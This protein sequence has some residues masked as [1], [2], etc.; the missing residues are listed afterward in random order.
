MDEVEL[1]IPETVVDLLPADGEN[2]ARDMERAVAGFER[3]VNATIETADD[4]A[5]VAAEV[6]DVVEHLQARIETYDEFVPELRAW[7]QSPAYAIAWR[8]LYADLVRQLTSHEGLADRLEQ[9]GN[10]R[11]V[12]D[13]IRL[14]D[15]KD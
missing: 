10:R 7:G 1:T 4:E 2:A 8:D 13:G 12:D 14:K 9:E 5:E 11:L 6:M 3:H 15:L